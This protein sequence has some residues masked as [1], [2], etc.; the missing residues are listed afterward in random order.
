MNESRI[1]LDSLESC[2]RRSRCI[3]YLIILIFRVLDSLMDS[4]GGL[5]WMK[6]ALAGDWWHHTVGTGRWPGNCCSR[7]SPY[8]PSG[9]CVLFPLGYVEPRYLGLATMV[10]RHTDLEPLGSGMAVASPRIW[11]RK[12][13]AHGKHFANDYGQARCKVKKQ[14]LVQ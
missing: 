4:T 6:G 11:R 5:F 12:L 10:L 2:Y 7:A 13:P 9:D 14:L 3:T 1:C 8:G